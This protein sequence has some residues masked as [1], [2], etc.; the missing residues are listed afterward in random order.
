MS[1]TAVKRHGQRST[2]HLKAL[3]AFRRA[4][5]NANALPE[6]IRYD[7]EWLA[8]WKLGYESAKREVARGR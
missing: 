5:P 4:H 7:R 2:L 6:A 1:F 3:R 8:T